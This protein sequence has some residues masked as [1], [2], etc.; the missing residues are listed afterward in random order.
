MLLTVLGASG[1][2]PR[3]GGACNGYL[4]QDDAVEVVL[5]LGNGCMSNL[6][7]WAD[8]TQLDGVIITHLHIDHFGDLYPLYYALRF[9]PQKPWGLPLYQPGGCLELLGRILSE[10]AKGYLPQ[11]FRERDINEEE[12]LSI[13]KM[14]F[15]FYPIT[16][17]ID[18]YSVRVIGEGWS[19]AYSSDTMPSQNLVKA[20][21]G[22]DLF[23]C[24]ST[25]PKEM[26]R[27]ASL[28]HMTSHQAAEIA[29]E[30]RVKCLLLTHIW[31]T[32]DPQ[33]IAREA[34]EVFD[35]H[36]EVAKEGMQINL[37]G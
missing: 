5:D 17:M 8:F 1:T 30:A 7:R 32:F 10:D 2:Y 9:H 28:G 13:G 6:V 24:E 23:I 29:K 33:K 15:R 18:G 35:G 19:L 27:E 34:A 11:V 14:T 25:L 16:H 4:L 20:A 12:D 21:E 37:E 36:I 3:P 31:P 26:E 22:V